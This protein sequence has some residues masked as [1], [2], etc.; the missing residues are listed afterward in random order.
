MHERISTFFNFQKIYPIH[1]FYRQEL[2]CYFYLKYKENS[3]IIKVEVV[4]AKM[5]VCTS[6]SKLSITFE[7]HVTKNNWW[8]FIWLMK[9]WLLV[10][11]IT[12]VYTI[13]T[14]MIRELPIIA[15]WPEETQRNHNH[16]F[17][18]VVWNVWNK[19]NNF[20]RLKIQASYRFTSSLKSIRTIWYT[21][22]FKTVL[23]C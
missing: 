21:R 10:S 16:P 7:L 5:L 13:S 20:A 11:L 23:S 3:F 15:T 9:I 17:F 22:N 6:Y 18:L 2:T 19:K 4:L 12:A 14:T 8:Y 1:Q